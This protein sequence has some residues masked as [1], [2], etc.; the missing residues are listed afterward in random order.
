MTEEF[1]YGP[2][3]ARLSTSGPLFDDIQFLVLGNSKGLER[4][5][6]YTMKILYFNKK[7]GWV[8]IAI[9][10]AFPELFPFSKNLW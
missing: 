10:N 8:I 7:N 6:R 1:H 5:N 4:G 9:F 3:R 2:R